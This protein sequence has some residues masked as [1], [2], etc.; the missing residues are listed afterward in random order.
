[1]IYEL[2]AG[3]PVVCHHG[4]PSTGMLYPP[5]RHDDVR[6]IGFDRSGYAD[7]PRRHGRSVADVVEE[8][9]AVVDS[10]GIDRF[11][12]WG[13][14]GGGPHALAC[15][16]LLPER[17]V[18]VATLGSPAPYDADGLDWFDGF[19]E[20]NVIEFRAA[21]AG[22]TAV[23]ALVEQEHAARAAAG[24]AALRDAWASLLSAV[25][26]EV[27]DGP[28]VDYFYE[29]LRGTGG[30]QGWVDDDLAL[31]RAWGFDLDSIAV[32]VLVRH[33]GEDRFVPAAHARWLAEHIPGAEAWIAPDEG[34]L[35]LYEH[36][37]PGV[38]DWLLQARS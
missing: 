19:G 18:A 31:V 29:L 3:F 36:A 16:A 34:H 37:V 26:A 5:W 10:L 32:P 21:A 6:L 22:E 38:Q 20:G 17:V 1:V 33:G 13:I 27:L 9:V 14:S 35:T 4:T 23:R 24:P 7:A 25:D 8:V 15:A 28:F 2:G 12:T 30:V 11:A